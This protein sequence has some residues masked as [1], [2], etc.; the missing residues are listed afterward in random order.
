MTGEWRSG[1][2]RKGYPPLPGKGEL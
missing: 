2:A 1:V